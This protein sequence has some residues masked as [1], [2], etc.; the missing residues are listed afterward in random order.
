MIKKF[1]TLI[2]GEFLSLS[3][4]EALHFD[5]KK[6]LHLKVSN[7]GLTRLSFKEDKIVDLFVYPGEYQNQLSLHK[8][9]NLFI[10]PGEGTFYMTLMGLSGI[11]QDFTI[12]YCAKTPIHPVT[13]EKRF[14]RPGPNKTRPLFQILQ[15]FLQG[16][17]PEGFQP[18]AYQ[19]THSIKVFS[20]GLR[21]KTTGCYQNENITVFEGL[22]KNQTSKSLALKASGFKGLFVVA[23]T[24]AVIAP[25]EEI[26]AYFMT[27]ER[28]M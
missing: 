2:L 11:K 22:L 25:G 27:K 18:I 19:E 4:L 20:S 7:R 21:L 3:C 5:E 10:S 14:Q 1:L 24:S 9:G 8:S 15:D 13:L 28:K 26:R 16:S 23:L 12:T 6:S 17:L